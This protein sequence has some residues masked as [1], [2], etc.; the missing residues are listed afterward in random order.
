MKIASRLLLSVVIFLSA[1]M[2]AQQPGHRNVIIFVADGLRHG[3][4]SPQDT[5]TLYRIRTDGV[6][7][8]NSYSLFPTFTT[9]NASAIATGHRL[10]D[11]ADFSNTIYTGFRTFDTGNFNRQPNTTIPFIEN[12]EILADLNSHENGDY[13]NEATLLEIARQNGYNTAA[14]GKVGPTAIQDVTQLGPRDK[15]FPAPQTI[16]IDDSTAYNI[17]DLAKPIPQTLALPKELVDRLLKLGIPLDAPGRTNGYPAKSRYDNGYIGDAQHPGTVLP[18]TVQQ[19]W[20]TDV[21][22]RAVLPMFVESGKPFVLLFWSRDPDATQHDQADNLNHL[23]PGINGPSSRLGVQ[24]A[25]HT[26]AR[27]MQWLDAN[28]KIKATTDVFITSDHGFATI[29]RHELDRD[30]TPT[31]SESAH[32]VY[33]DATG[34][35]DTPKG[36]MPNGFVAMDLALALHTNLW[37]PDA[38]APAGSASPYKQVRLTTEG[39]PHPDQWDRPS[40]GNG[41]LGQ[42]VSKPDGSDAMAIVASNGGSDLIYVP[43]KNPQTVQQIVKALLGFDY[44]ASIFVEDAYGKLPGTLPLSLIDLVGTSTLPRPAIVVSFKVFYLKPGDLMSGISF[45]DTSLQ[46]G[47]GNHGSFGRECTWNNMAAI[48]P[49]FK[50]GYTDPAPV[51]NSDITPTLAGILGLKMPSNGKLQGRVIEESL[52]GKRDAPAPKITPVVSQP[53]PDH[54]LRTVLIMQ[55]YGGQKYFDSACMATS[56]TVE[57]D[58]CHQQ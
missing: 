35:L 40:H 2:N 54:N 15:R 33:Y 19:Q 52:A 1:L 14:I 39:Q 27:L 17:D 34:H 29:S 55:E 13:L 8:E 11:T 37:D 41:F 30:N 43:D 28:P 46:E 58:F 23:S 31:K 4:V 44:V 24:N 10:G 18:N 3:S 45:S 25:D 22:T 42:T 9:A 20:L 49:D 16:I 38:P 5:P 50:R 56:A 32:H 6:N 47:Q 36:F 53:D 48:G 12:N 51:A 7:F 57:P 26:L 21:T